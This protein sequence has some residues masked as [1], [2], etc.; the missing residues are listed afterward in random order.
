M[1]KMRAASTLISEPHTRL[2]DMSSGSV[3][4]QFSKWSHQTQAKNGRP[5]GLDLLAALT[6]ENLQTVRQQNNDLDGYHQDGTGGEEDVKT[7]ES[8]FNTY[9]S[10]DAGSIAPSSRKDVAGLS[11]T[12]AQCL[13]PDEA[14]PEKQATGSTKR[15][16]R[17][18]GEGTQSKQRR[19]STSSVSSH[20]FVNYKPARGR[21]RAKQLASMTKEEIEAEKQARLERNRVCARE[22]RRRKKSRD[23]EAQ[24]LIAQLKSDI[25]EKEKMIADLQ[26]Q[27]EIFRS[28]NNRL[29]RETD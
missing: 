8:Q 7:S 16:R 12:P 11:S 22:C 25:V 5:S 10:S 1:D 4:F 26:C 17:S 19:R 13:E 14:T 6:S 21:A 15:C 23:N 28:S 27:L 3:S 18:K 20:T 2:V 29:M 24:Q 9:S